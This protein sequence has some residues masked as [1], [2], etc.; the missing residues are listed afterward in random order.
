MI[1]TVAPRTRAP[2]R[3][4]RTVP[5]AFGVRAVRR[6]VG[7][8]VACAFVAIGWGCTASKET[9]DTKPED[10]FERGQALLAKGQALPSRSETMALAQQIEALAW[11]EGASAR[12]VTFYATAAALEERSWRIDRHDDDAKAATLAYRAASRDLSARGACD[13]AIR[14]AKLEGE[15]ARDA[16]V[17]YTELYRIQRRSSAEHAVDAT[18]DA[19]GAGGVCGG[20]V[21]AALASLVAFRPEPQEL[22]AIDRSLASEGIVALVDAGAGTGLVR[23]IPKITRVE[24][25]TGPEVARVVVH[26]DRP[27]RY[28]VFDVGPDAKKSARTY[29]ELDGVE[30]GDR[31]A[32]LPLQ[33]IVSRI[34]TEATTTGSRVALDLPG[35]A[36]R[37]VFQLLEPYRIVIDVAR[38]PPG[39]KDGAARAVSRVVLDPGHGGSDPG[40]RG[41]SGVSEKDVTLAMAHQ[42]APALARIGIEVK[43]TRDDDRYVTLEERTAEANAFGADLFVSLHCNASEK[44]APHGLE[45]YVLD[46]TTS[47]MAGRVAARENAASSSASNEVAQLLASMRLA[48][49]STRSTHLAEL[50]LRS[51][52]GALASYGD[53]L[54]GGVHRAGFYVLVGARMPAVLFEM[55]YV[56]NAIEEQRLA[57]R[58]YQTHLADAVVN[59]IK[60]YREG[61]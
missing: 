5:V 32:Q 46:T 7:A 37:R 43:L 40:A 19:G 33:G 4:R 56:S 6:L 57:S 29:V 21:S 16:K 25:W 2:L 12:A 48:D 52:T 22:D 51:S 1:P 27:A 59:A 54:D 28:R 31:A 44:P 53:V 8:G 3:D 34:S 39:V 14:G 26:L 49:Q 41:P 60:A 50:L 38:H 23:T 17:T 58:E 45:T 61:R 11:K 42:I 24:Q 20:V 18:S 10:P 35:P 30:L 47:D 55:G 15:L 13:A 36:Y 9:V